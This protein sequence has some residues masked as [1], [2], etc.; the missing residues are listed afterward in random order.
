M[1]LLGKNPRVIVVLVG[2]QSSEPG[3]FRS[4]CARLQAKLS[5]TEGGSGKAKTGSGL[6]SLLP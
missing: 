5:T 6:E 1:V 4:H 2:L 3:C